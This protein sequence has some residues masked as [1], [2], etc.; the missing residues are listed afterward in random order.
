M[1]NND[2]SDTPYPY[3]NSLL[4]VPRYVIKEHPNYMTY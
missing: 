1:K 4:V 2:T 3:N